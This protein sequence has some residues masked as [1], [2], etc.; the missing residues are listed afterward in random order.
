MCVYADKLVLF[1]GFGFHGNEDPKLKIPTRQKN[2]HKVNMVRT[3]HRRREEERKPTGLKAQRYLE[4]LLAMS[5]KNNGPKLLELPE[6]KRSLK[7]KFRAATSHAL[8]NNSTIFI[9]DEFSE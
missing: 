7:K 9:E 6:R 4:E 8:K 1:L 2:D 5:K 3:R